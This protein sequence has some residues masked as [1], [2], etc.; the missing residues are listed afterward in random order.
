MIVIVNTC[1]SRY[2]IWS[3]CRFGNL[4]TITIIIIIIIISIIIII[5]IIIPM[6]IPIITTIIPE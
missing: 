4:T 1:I 6:I 3:T 2:V 5:I